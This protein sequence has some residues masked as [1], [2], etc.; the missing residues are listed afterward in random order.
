MKI[1]VTISDN[2]VKNK[3]NKKSHKNQPIDHSKR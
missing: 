1:D 2:D 3:L